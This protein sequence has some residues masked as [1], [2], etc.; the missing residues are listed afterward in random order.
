MLLV[1][2]SSYNDPIQFL[3]PKSSQQ[4]RFHTTCPQPQQRVREATSSTWENSPHDSLSNPVT[5]SGLAK[6]VRAGSRAPES[7]AKSFIPTRTLLLSITL[8][9]NAVLAIT[10]L[11]RVCH[12]KLGAWD[13]VGS[14]DPILPQ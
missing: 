12:R 14:S 10:S 2:A 1:A 13:G 5:P 4:G 11:H 3:N 7:R 6:R 9:H 8:L